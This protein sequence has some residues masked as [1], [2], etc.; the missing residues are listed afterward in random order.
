[1]RVLE[2]GC[3]EGGNLLPFAE[4]GCE[5][6]GIDQA[7]VRI[8]QAESFFV[9]AGYEGHFICADFFQ[10]EANQ[11]PKFDL[12]L[13]HDVIEHIPE[14]DRF[15]ESVR[16]FLKPGGLLFMAFPAWQMPFGGHQQICRSRLL[17][18]LPFFHLLPRPLYKGM[19]TLFK[20][21]QGTIAELL[22]IKEC[23]ISIGQFRRY[24]KKHHYSIR[25]QMLYFINPHY[26]IKFHLRPRRLARWLGKCPY[27]RNFFCTSAFF[28]LKDQL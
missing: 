23:G 1:M 24:L 7:A 8:E 9:Q 5:V 11:F 17:S 2:I 19:L 14:K 27:V 25:R 3:G 6:I 28:L 12:I 22:S 13:V 18:H 26:E 4:L 10:V 21:P 15:F 16:E 20:E